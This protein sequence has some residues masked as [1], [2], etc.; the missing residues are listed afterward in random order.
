MANQPDP[1]EVDP[2]LEVGIGA[3]G[4]DCG[5]DRLGPA[6]L[7]WR[8]GSRRSK[9]DI[10]HVDAEDD[11]APPRQVPGQ[12][13]VAE[14]AADARQTPEPVRDHDQRQVPRSAGPHLAVVRREVGCPSATVVKASPS[15]AAGMATSAYFLNVS[16]AAGRVRRRR[17]RRSAR[18][19]PRAVCPQSRAGVNR[20]G[21]RADTDPG[22]RFGVGFPEEHC[23]G[24]DRDG[25]PV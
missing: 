15:A 8:A 24:P 25:L 3:Q 9:V 17:D 7:M 11:H 23:A 18:S 10:I 4:I 16:A 21:D 5:E 20:P 13:V 22:D 19:Q 12:I 1:A 6:K 2:A 14:I